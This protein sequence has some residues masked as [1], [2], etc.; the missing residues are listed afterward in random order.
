[1]TPGSIDLIKLAEYLHKQIEAYNN[2]DRNKL[3]RAARRRWY[4]QIK[5]EVN[6]YNKAVG[7]IAIYF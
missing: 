1:M 5:H 4:R 3:M 6:K 7:F 2:L